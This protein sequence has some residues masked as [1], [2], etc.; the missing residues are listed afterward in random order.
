MAPHSYLSSESISVSQCWKVNRASLGRKLVLRLFGDESSSCQVVF[1]QL[2][3]VWVFVMLVYLYKDKE[4]ETCVRERDISGL[5][6]TG[7]PIKSLLFFILFSYHIWVF[8]QFLTPVWFVV[9]IPFIS[10]SWL[11][12]IRPSLSEKKRMIIS[13]Y[14]SHWAVENS[15]ISSEA[16]ADNRN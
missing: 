4:R 15:L 13:F 10:L 3:F 5:P 11:C 6:S 2:D 16:Q 9:W 1:H 12:A 14:Q 7:K 8:S